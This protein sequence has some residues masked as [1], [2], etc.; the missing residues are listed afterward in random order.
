MDD[1]ARELSA[2]TGLFL[3]YG[4]RGIGKTRTLRELARNHLGERKVRWIDLQAGGAGDGALVDSS[5]MIENVFAEAR[6][7]DVII[8]DHFEMALK[9]T[10]HQ[11][12]LSWSTEGREKHLHLIIG[13]N[14]DYFKGLHQLAQQYQVRLRSYRQMPLELEEIEPFL[15]FYLFPDRPIGELEMPSQLHGQLAAAD[16]NIG[17]IIE[18]AERA[19]DQITPATLE[20]PRSGRRGGLMLG[21]VLAMILV[22]AAGA[23]LLLNND[24]STETL[25]VTDKPGQALVPVAGTIEDA[26]PVTIQSQPTEDATTAAMT[27]AIEVE[28]Y[29]E[30]ESTVEDEGMAEVV[31]SADTESTESVGWGANPDPD[32]ESNAPETE[33]TAVPSVTPDLPV[34]KQIAVT[35]VAD[36]I[37]LALPESRLQRDLRISKTWIEQ[38]E[39]GVGTVQFMLLNA[40]RFDEAAYYEYIAQLGRKGA[41][42]SA[43]RIFRTLTGG[44]ETYSV[45]YGEF[46]SREAASQ[47]KS[48]LPEILRKTSP[49]PRSVGGLL[50]EIKRL[51]EKN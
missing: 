42:R 20:Q 21:G 14:S 5:D 13:A 36:S 22:V 28:L 16:G 34:K 19:G 8:A 25:A 35:A 37:V 33:V 29:T 12:F 6:T 50:D 32:A 11:L 15:S 26:P 27:A 38:A 48:N 3:L 31:A 51:E 40:R 46:T 41:D 43:I 2:G 9:K 4:E 17:A 24:R 30:P 1:L 10:R 44:Q 23:W 39:P 18:V 7:G 47:A 45:I 49:I